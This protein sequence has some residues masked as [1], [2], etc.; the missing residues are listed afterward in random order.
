MMKTTLRIAALAVALSAATGA[1]YAKDPM[2]GGAKMYASK[3][4]IENAV[5]SKDHTTLV[6]AV[7]A[8]GLVETLEGK[9]PFTV[10]APTNEAFAKLPAGTVETLLKPENKAKLVKILTCHVVSGDIMASAVKKMVKDAGGEY[11]IKTVGGC[12]IKA[13]TKGSKV[14][15]TDEAGGTAHVTIADVKQSNGEIHVIDAVLL[16]KM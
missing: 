15:L 16:P 10:F 4:I 12:V 6:A 8:A 7:K 5:N 9:G 1:A 13:M 2:V 11:D 3:N 14:T